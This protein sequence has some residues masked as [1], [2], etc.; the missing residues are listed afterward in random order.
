LQQVHGVRRDV[1]IVT[2]PLLAAPWYLEEL[3]RRDGFAVTTSTYS[4]VG[5]SADIATSARRFGRPVTVALTVPDSERVRLGGPWV[6]TG[7][8][9]IED[10]TSNTTKGAVRLDSVRIAAVAARIDSTL[11]GRVP[12]SAPDPVHDYF[13]RVLSCPRLSIAKTRSTAQLA[14]LDSTCNLR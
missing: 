11:G 5:R 9:A 4:L 7:L 2:M 14:S 13:L 8:A 6:V 10:R 12:R 3:Q 1:T